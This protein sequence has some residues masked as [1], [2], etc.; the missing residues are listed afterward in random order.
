MPGKIPTDLKVM[1]VDPVPAMAQ[2]A[3]A[4]GL[5]AEGEIKEAKVQAKRAQA[6][7][8]SGTPPW[9]RADDIIAYEP[10]KL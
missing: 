8:K 9:L 1:V 7:L 10:P 2:L 5:F 6:K 3:T 4:Q